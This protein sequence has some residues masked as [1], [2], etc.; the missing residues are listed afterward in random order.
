[1]DWIETLR[2]DLDIIQARGTDADRSGLQAYA[3]LIR[4]VIEGRSGPEGRSHASQQTGQH[5]LSSGQRDP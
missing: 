5:P 1:M 4:E 2:A 3:R